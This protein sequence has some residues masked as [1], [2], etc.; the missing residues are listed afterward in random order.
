MKNFSIKWKLT[1]SF[2][3]LG[4][5]LVGIHVFMATSTSES[6]KLSYIFDSQQENIESLS[7]KIKQKIERTVF[8]EFSL[9]SD[10]K[11][12]LYTDG[13]VAITNSEG[14]ELGE[15]RILKS[16]KK[17]AMSNENSLDLTNN[18]YSLFEEHRNNHPLPDDVTLVVFEWNKKAF[19]TILSLDQR[20][21][22]EAS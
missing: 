14:K 10:D 4:M 3:L 22:Q 15:R 1:I 16:L 13:L 20:K 2:V 17:I 11:I 7:K 5:T 9:K 6:D 12:I 21:E 8:Y 19:K 18:L